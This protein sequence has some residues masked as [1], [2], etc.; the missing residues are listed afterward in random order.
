MRTDISGKRTASRL[1]LV[2]LLAAAVVLSCTPGRA[3]TGLKPLHQPADYRQLVEWGLANSPFFT[4]SALGIEAGKLGETDAVFSYIPHLQIHL[5]YYLTSTVET[6]QYNLVFQSSGVNPLKAHFSVEAA[7]DVTRLAV[8]EHLQQVEKNIRIIAE[9]ILTLHGLERVIKIKAMD[10][11]LARQ[12][13]K[14]AK[15]ARQ[16]TPEAL[17]ET[18]VAEQEVVVTSNELQKLQLSRQEY[19]D[20][21]KLLLNLP[22]DA[23]LELDLDKARKQVLEGFE[24]RKVTAKEFLE[25]SHEVKKAEIRS[26]LQDKRVSLAWSKYMPDLYLGLATEDPL[27]ETNRDNDWYLYMGLSTTLWDNM[28]RARD[29]TRQR[30]KVRES[31]TDLKGKKAEVARAWR[32]S[33]IDVKL[34]EADMKVAH[35]QAKLESFKE[36]QNLAQFRTNQITYG[37]LAEQSSKYLQARIKEVLQ[38]GA[39]ERALLGLAFDS[40][41]MLDRFVSGTSF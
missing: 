19:L 14:Y 36:K 30:L 35:E 33:A 37:I 16:D 27:Y 13:V 29:V 17:I 38:E 25:H 18:Q 24:P 6:R 7:K 20:A 5:R 28:D 22:L 39:H 23:T 31:R 4:D 2:A 15:A 26:R 32:K 10:L 9:A 34:S 8:Q 40:G 1:A 3:D 21:I 11:D 41:W 12:R